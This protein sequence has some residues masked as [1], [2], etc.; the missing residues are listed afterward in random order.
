MD[1]QNGGHYICKESHDLFL[2]SL[3]AL[4]DKQNLENIVGFYKDEYFRQRSQKKWET[5][6]SE[7][8]GSH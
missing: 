6:S 7:M 5:K 3:G 2:Y 1:I 4:W 8:K